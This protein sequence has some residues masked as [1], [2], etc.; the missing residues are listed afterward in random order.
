MNLSDAAKALEMMEQGWYAAAHFGEWWLLHSSPSRVDPNAVLIG[1]L[2]SSQVAALAAAYDA[3]YGEKETEYHVLRRGEPV[4]LSVIP[5]RG[6][7][8]IPRY[9]PDDAEDREESEGQA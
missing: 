7:A 6:P 1:T 3:L 5:N 4:P 8:P 2:H 9:Y